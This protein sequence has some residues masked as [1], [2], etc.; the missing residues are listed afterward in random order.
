MLAC[1]IHQAK[2]LRLE[3]RETP[4]L[5]PYEV[6][7]R[8]GAGGICGSDLHYFNHGGVGDFKL[9][10]PMVLGHEVSG[11]VVKLGSAV[12]SVKI[13]DHV[14]VDP[15]RPCRTCDYC[16]MG[17][18]N[19]CR[20]MRFFGS[21]A[22]FPHVQGGFSEFFKVVDFQCYV[23]PQN[24]DFQ[25]VA[26]AEPL[27]VTL[28]AVARVGSL[29]G[30]KV[31]ITGSGPIGVLTIAAAKLAGAS[32]ITVTDLFD[33]PLEIAKRMGATQVVNTDVHPEKLEEFQ[34]NKGIFDVSF[35]ASGNARALE[36]C[37]QATR[38]G[39]SMV[40]IG[41]LPPGLTSA[42]INRI[43]AKE[44]NF[45]GTF[46]F[47]QEF[48]WAVNALVTNS[49][50][51]KPILTAQFGFQDA[52]QAFELAANRHKAMKVSLKFE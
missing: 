4:E 32:E 49:I 40:Q 2:D 24:I 43:L 10:E 3:T 15:S 37:V 41:I 14:A 51:V 34:A 13:G 35:E 18:S 28:H 30:A 19:L 23:V 25:V 1:V 47:H 38:P 31:L 42:P 36:T 7:V 45:F 50:N 46:R 21:A 27:A 29:L 5:K 39:G 33:E 20:N 17:R 26:C 12:S 52:V 11:E 44:L 9:Q 16:L 8:F 6:L 22:L 48:R